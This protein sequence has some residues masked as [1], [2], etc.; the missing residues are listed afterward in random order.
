M[1]D[2]CFIDE[3]G[4]ELCKYCPLDKDKRGVYST[5]G[6]MSAGCEGSHCDVAEESYLESNKIYLRK[7]KIRKLKMPL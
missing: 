6:G 7:D 2:Y 1:R 4:D 3:I 5:L